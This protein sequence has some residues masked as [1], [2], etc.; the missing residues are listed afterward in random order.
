MKCSFQ[1]RYF[2][3]LL[4]I[5]TEGVNAPSVGSGCPGAG[6][7]FLLWSWAVLYGANL[8]QASACTSVPSTCCFN[9]V[10]SKHSLEQRSELRFPPPFAVQGPQH[11]PLPSW[12]NIPP[13]KI[14]EKSPHQENWA[15]NS[16]YSNYQEVEIKGQ[17]S[18][19][20]GRNLRQS[21]PVEGHSISHRAAGDGRWETILKSS[22]SCPQNTWL[23]LGPA[24]TVRE[25]F[26]LVYKYQLHCIMRAQT[27]S[28]SALK[29]HS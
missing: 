15:T 18:L 12:V 23:R 26:I 29:I 28:A 21:F 3:V 16:D 17:V 22:K 5:L 13:C 19:N 10:L 9:D 20:K 27:I 14:Q 8:Q 25:Y 7:C 1:C 11:C 2:L 24:V 4:Q 6:L